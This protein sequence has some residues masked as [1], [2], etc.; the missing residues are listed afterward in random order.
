MVWYNMVM[1][2]QLKFLI[3]L[4]LPLT[5]IHKC[6]CCNKIY[7]IYGYGSDVLCH[8]CVYE[9]RNFAIV[10]KLNCACTLVVDK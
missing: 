10:N 7:G 5:K 6:G 2:E 9:L 1:N 8:F 4:N 3:R